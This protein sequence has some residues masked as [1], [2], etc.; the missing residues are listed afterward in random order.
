VH[1]A[2]QVKVSTLGQPTV[3]VALIQLALA[4]KKWIVPFMVI[5]SCGLLL[6]QDVAP[7]LQAS[8]TT[9]VSIIMRSS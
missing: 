5:A 6:L 3:L 9:I 8:V 1:G 7:P 2:K 4:N